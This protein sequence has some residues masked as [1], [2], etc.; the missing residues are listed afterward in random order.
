MYKHIKCACCNL[1]F[2]AKRK[3][4][5]KGTIINTVLAATLI[6]LLRHPRAITDL[7]PN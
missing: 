2:V 5:R 3:Y 1:K 6:Q 4:E 7:S